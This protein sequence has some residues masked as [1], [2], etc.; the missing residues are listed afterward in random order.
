MNF[1]YNY[2]FHKLGKLNFRRMR[3]K[4]LYGGL[5]YSCEKLLV[6]ATWYIMR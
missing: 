5:M 2:F 3:G 4:G 6:I 1:C